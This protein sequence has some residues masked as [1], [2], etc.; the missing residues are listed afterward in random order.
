MNIIDIAILAILAISIAYGLYKGFVHAL[1]SLGCGLLAFVLA[2]TFSPKLA[3]ELSNNPGLSST[4]ATYTDSF[5]RVEDSAVKNYAVYQLNEANI[6]QLLADH[7]HLPAVIEDALK[8]NL[9]SNALQGKGLNTV[10]DYVSNTIVSIAISILCFIVC[11]IAA[12][13]VLSL[14]VNIISHVFKLPLLKQ[15]D[16]LAGGVL[17]LLRGAVL[18]Y[19]L[20]LALPLIATIVPIDAVQNLVSESTLAPIFQSDGLF[21]RVIGS[22]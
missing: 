19:V 10:N 12:H 8:D 22:L 9:L 4:L 3:E 16:W 5:T 17:G 18:L 2:F 11:Y 6:D 7:V 14:L 21:A 20:F 1:L 13:L 15:L